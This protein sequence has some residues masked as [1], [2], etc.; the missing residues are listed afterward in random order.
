MFRTAT[1]INNELELTRT[2][3]LSRTRN[4]N[5]APQ[6]LEEALS[7]APNENTK[8]LFWSLPRQLMIWDADRVNLDAIFLLHEPHHEVIFT[9]VQP[10][11]R[12]LVGFWKSSP[13]NKPQ[14]VFMLYCH[15]RE[16][17]CDVLACVAALSS[18]P[19]FSI[20]TPENE[21]MIPGPNR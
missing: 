20:I 14:Q 3:P 7:S 17:I 15:R 9:M 4:R 13:N 1:E 18:L 21:L 2:N 5:I 12:R 8:L 16:P 19:Q 10:F 6:E 11:L